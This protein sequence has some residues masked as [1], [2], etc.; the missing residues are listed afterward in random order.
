[1]LR[2][3]YENDPSFW[4]IIKQLAIEMEPEL[5][6]IDK[7]LDVPPYNFMLHISPFHDEVNDYYHWHIE[8]IPSLTKTAGFEWGTGFYIN[9]VPPEQA[10]AFLREVEV[11][12]RR[13]VGFEGV[14]APPG[15][16]CPVIEAVRG[17][18]YEPVVDSVTLGIAGMSCASC[19][20]RVERAVK[21]LAPSGRA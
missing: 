1:M 12:A 6:Q 7:I 8:I 4:A 20:A 15:A 19:A 21:G 10:A 14:D 11:E 13:Q 3:R 9:P 2:D 5:A 16:S 18:G 17:A